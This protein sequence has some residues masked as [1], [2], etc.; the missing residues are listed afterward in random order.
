[1]SNG[2]N[3]T[4]DG[5]TTFISMSP[6]TPG[7]WVCKK[8]AVSLP[9]L[10]ELSLTVYRVKSIDLKFQ[11]VWKFIPSLSLT[12]SVEEW[13]DK[14]ICLLKVTMKNHLLGPRMSDASR[15]SFVIE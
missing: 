10:T 13:Y 14:G 1:M 11:V 12:S 15:P 9:D 4:E 5:R 7:P 3:V 8:A 6:L 2:H